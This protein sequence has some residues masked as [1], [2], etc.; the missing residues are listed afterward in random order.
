MKSINEKGSARAL[1]F[2]CAFVLC[3]CLAVG[4]APHMLFSSRDQ[5]ASQMTLAL[6]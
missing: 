2:G 5:P 3:Y 1:L 4:V 6:R